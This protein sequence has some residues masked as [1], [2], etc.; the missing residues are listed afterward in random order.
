MTRC[1]AHQ[2]KKHQAKRHQQQQQPPPQFPGAP[3]WEEG[4]QKGKR[5]E[6]H[7]KDI[8]SSE[9]C[10]VLSVSASERQRSAQRV[11]HFHKWQNQ[12]TL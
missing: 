8:N 4:Q 2:Q 12:V 3:D 11:W 10:R 7:S 9:D 6:E 1:E 5:G